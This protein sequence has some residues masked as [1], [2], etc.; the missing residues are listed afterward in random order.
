MPFTAISFVVCSVSTFYVISDMILQA[1]HG[2][3]TNALQLCRLTQSS[4]L[5]IIDV[6]ASSM[7]NNII[8]TIV[9]NIVR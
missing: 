1:G 5:N 3:V 6:V 4:K 8:E 2:I 7:R 9:N